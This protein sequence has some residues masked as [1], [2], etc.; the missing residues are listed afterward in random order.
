MAFPINQ[1]VFPTDFSE[2]AQEALPFAAEIA[3]K[4]GAELVLFHSSQATS[5]L[6]PNFKDSREKTIEN[7]SRYFDELISELRKEDSF[8]SI[9]ISTTLQ[10]GQASTSLLNQI[11]KDKPGL[12]VMGTRGESNNRN[13]IFG[14]VTTNIIQKSEVPVLA[15]PNGSTPNFK[16]IIFTTDCK[17]GDIAALEQTIDF[18]KLFDS[19]IDILH[20]T[21]NKDFENELRFR[22]FRDLVN[23]R[24]SYNNLDFHIRHEEDFFPGIADFISEQSSSLLVMVRY[25]KTFW[26]RLT[27][28]DHSKEMAFYSDI[29][30][31]MLIGDQESF[32]STL[33]KQSEEYRA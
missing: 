24:I 22:G 6:A 8:T 13:V 30:M 4:A 28:R 7:I 3:K 11:A 14:S 2:N 5:D 21:E 15:V 33:Y 29:P 31:L 27:D 9:K 23:S 20:I 1:I 17:Q 16:N 25:E 18:A 32:K 26:E 10:T 12:V 19:A